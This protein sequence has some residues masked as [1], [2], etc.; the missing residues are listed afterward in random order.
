MEMET[1]YNV[2]LSTKGLVSSL[3]KESWAWVMAQRVKH[4][5]HNVGRESESQ[6][7]DKARYCSLHLPSQALT[8]Q[9][10][11]EAGEFLKDQLALYTAV[12]RRLGF[13]AGEMA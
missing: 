12:N 11:A 4:L 10:E 2:Y 3:Q 6:D 5:L 7:P 13:R 9:W 1:T 8:A